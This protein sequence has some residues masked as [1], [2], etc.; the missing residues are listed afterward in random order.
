M[1]WSQKWRKEFG[2]E[3]HK[4]SLARLHY[5]TLQPSDLSVVITIAALSP[6]AFA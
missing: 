4:K 6:P 2:A 5:V 3:I 1:A